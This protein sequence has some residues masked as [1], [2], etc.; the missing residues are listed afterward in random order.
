METKKDNTLKNEKQNVSKDKTVKKSSSEPQAKENT[1]KIKATK[2]SKKTIKTKKIKRDNF[3][4]PEVIFLIV[5]TCIVSVIMGW[6][7]CYKLKFKNLLLKTDSNLEQFIETYNKVTEDYYGEVDKG[8]LINGA[9]AG[10]LEELEDDYSTIIDEDSKSTFDARLE[11]QYTGVGIEVTNTIDN[12]IAIVNVFENSSA[13]EQ[14]IRIGDI[15]LSVDDIN[16]QG[17]TTTT[18]IDYLGQT[19]NKEYTV[20]V[21]RDNNKLE[22]KVTKKTITINS[23]TSK[24]YQKNN[25]K[26]GYIRIDIF[27]KMASTQFQEKLIDFEN[28]SI[29]SLIID[30]RNNTGGYLTTASNIISLFLDSTNIIYQTDKKGEITKFYSNGTITKNY[31]II[32][33]QN[34]ISASAS[35]LLSISLKEQYKATVVG[36]K[37]YGKGT[38]QELITLDDGTEY[39]Y[40]SKKWLSPSGK[41]I[42]KIG[43]IPD[44][45]MEISKEY[46]MNPTEDND[47][48]LQKALTLLAE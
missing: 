2:S 29:D 10:M 30:V 21:L 42:N 17:K 19:N 34:E 18:L 38:I 48:Q 36:T 43:V 39:K 16:L 8:R 12:N 6:A 7:V 45:E 26:I 28:Q 13:H 33:L 31:P 44:V 15:I 22:K 35:E 4:S 24:L 37:S 11:G 41:W 23:V 47:N 40:T 3:K 9:I 20:T 46:V 5:V 14:D 25:K 32:I 27:S 1:K